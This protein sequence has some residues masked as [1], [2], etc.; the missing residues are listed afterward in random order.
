MI[1]EKYAWARWTAGPR[2]GPAA[3]RNRGASLATGEF[4]AFTDDDCLPSAG[5]LAAYAAAIDPAV[6]VYEGKTTCD[7][8]IRSP[9]EHSPINLTGGYLWSC[10]MMVRRDF[11]E[12]FP[13]D[14]SFPYPH[15]EDTYFREQLKRRGEHFVFIGDA[16]IDH[17]PRALPP[18]R[19]WAVTHE[20]EVIYYYKLHDLPPSLPVYLWRLVKNK[21]RLI[22]AYPL[23]VASLSAMYHALAEILGVAVHYGQWKR[24]HRHLLGTQV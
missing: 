8:G 10:N 20:C 15:M 13:F 24:R 2:K 22:L 16:V 3:N 14:E 17:P 5:W 21:I 11:F 18:G 19:N 1:R 6:N 7:A 23:G 12:R 9:R 4:I